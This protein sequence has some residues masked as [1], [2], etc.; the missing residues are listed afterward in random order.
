[1][2]GGWVVAVVMVGWYSLTNR[3]R[4]PHTALVS[5]LVWLEPEGRIMAK[6][7]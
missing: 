4:P 1:M 3:G 6:R 5:L 7:T 2:V